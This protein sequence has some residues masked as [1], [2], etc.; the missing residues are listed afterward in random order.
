[1]IYKELLLSNICMFILKCVNL[2][3]CNSFRLTLFQEIF[4]VF[5][6]F[7]MNVLLL[8][9]NYLT[10]YF[11]M[12]FSKNFIQTTILN[13]SFAYANLKIFI[14]FSATFIY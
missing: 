11:Q 2:S 4:L 14:E 8:I 13:F 6:C 3:F 10:G 5:F 12:F 9:N 1:M 7:K